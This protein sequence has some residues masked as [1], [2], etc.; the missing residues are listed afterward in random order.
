[1]RPLK[2]EIDRCLNDSGYT[3]P[4]AALDGI[5]DALGELSDE[6]A[7]RVSRVL[8]RAGVEAGVV[9]LTRLPRATAPTRLRLLGVVRRVATATNA[10]R[11]L[12]PLLGVL[13]DPDPRCRRAAFRALGN[14]GDASAEPAL[15]A[16][17]TSEA[18][19]EQRALVEALGKLGGL[20]AAR[21]LATLDRTDAELG[22]RALR[23]EILIA[24]RALREAGDGT[25]ELE[26]ELGTRTR[27]A[28]LCRRG[29]AEL[30]A[31]ELRA[32][33]PALRNDGRVDVV[34]A[35]TL[36]ELFRA[37]TA[38]EFALVIGLDSRL[39]DPIERIARALAAE[40]TRGLLTRWTRGSLRFRL[41][42]AAGGH[43]RALTW[44]IA[45]RVGELAP[46]LINDSRD[47]A[48]TARVSAA[49]TELLLVPRVQPDPRFD[50]RVRDVP[51]TSHPTIAAALA[52][53]A[54]ARVSDVVW[55][56]FMGSG[57]ELVERAR[58]G[59]YA[60]LIGSDIDH[61]A[62][63]AAR[64]NLARAAVDRV[65]LLRGDARTLSPG[66]VQLIVTNPP[67]GRR[68][69]RD[70]TA[71]DLLDAFLANAAR[72]LAPGGRLV[73]LSPFEQRTARA[74]LA[75]GF[76]LAPGPNVD[77]G[78]FSARLQTFTRR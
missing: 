29:L 75:A 63:E 73:W 38:L 69:T 37:R 6:H 72:V 4:A 57:L 25:I 33:A 5:L 15:I 64:Q 42:W 71:G 11:L 36:A 65:E 74:G 62:L 28:A 14:L 49:S 2:P 56:P 7:E 78:G 23:A 1:V 46:A 22:R 44:N 52:R 51:G 58:L 16:R 48:W 55:D 41:H 61:S 76:L 31:S 77:M 35:G 53:T 43:Q 17:L 12:A 47:A 32:Y 50:Y 8:E 20:D 30:L 45:K 19:P 27:V 39:T 34:H 26:R 10:P 67:M 40:D 18:L 54:G 68:V 13:D 60:R 21:A 9:A 59:P 70:G 66:A 24:R 3:P